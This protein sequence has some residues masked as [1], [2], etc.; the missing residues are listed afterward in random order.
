VEKPLTASGAARELSKRMGRLVRPRDI[1]NL[2]Y[3]RR[4]EDS[5]C[6]VVAGRRL[7]PRACLA[8]IE[9]V[10]RE[11]ERTDKAVTSEEP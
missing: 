9:A 10:L 8:R 6:P 11:S 5:L 3:E 2:L 1:T 4:I 7:I